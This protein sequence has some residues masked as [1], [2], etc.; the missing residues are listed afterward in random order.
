MFHLDG[1][2]DVLNL[3]ADVVFTSQLCACRLK[4]LWPDA[5][6]RNLSTSGAAGGF[7]WGWEVST[8]PVASAVRVGFAMETK[9]TWNK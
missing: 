3:C 8:W 4:L 7:C 5:L 9:H 1:Q 6:L 2:V